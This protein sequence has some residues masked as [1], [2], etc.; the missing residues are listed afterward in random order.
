MGGDHSSRK[1]MAFKSLVTQEHSSIEHQSSCNPINWK[2]DTQ[3]PKFG[4]LTKLEIGLKLNQNL[5]CRSGKWKIGIK[6]SSLAN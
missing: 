1:C 2:L 5:I 3:I 6:F 4:K